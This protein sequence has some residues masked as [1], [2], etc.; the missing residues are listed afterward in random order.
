M[1]GVRLVFTLPVEDCGGVFLVENF[2]KVTA[3]CFGVGFSPYA[4]GTLGTLAGI[5]VYLIFSCFTWPVYAISVLALFFLAVF[6]S[7]EAERIFNKKDAQE[8]VI[9]EIVGFQF[10]MFLVAPTVLHILAGFILFRF[11]DILKPYPV[12]FCER[13]LPGGYGVVADDVAAGIYGN[14]ILLLLVKFAGI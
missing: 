9:D 4:P 5:P 8:I 12:S 7:R 10:T 1:Q 11:F 2:I 6:V 14:I 3:T 13:R